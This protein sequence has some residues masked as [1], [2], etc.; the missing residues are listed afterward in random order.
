M[1]PLSQL[2]AQFLPRP[3]ICFALVLLYTGMLLSIVALIGYRSYDFINY[4]DLPGG[5]IEDDARESLGG[6]VE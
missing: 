4:I 6:R 5:I 2:V 1:T 3:F